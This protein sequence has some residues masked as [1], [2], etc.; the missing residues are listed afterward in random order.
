MSE[1]ETN[2][3]ECVA[4]VPSAAV[5]V[6]TYVYEKPPNTG[7]FFENVWAA[8][9]RNVVVPLPVGVTASFAETGTEDENWK[10]ASLEPLVVAYEA[11]LTLESDGAATG[12]FG[13]SGIE[14]LGDVGV[15]FG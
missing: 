13:V 12:G 10:C 4:I 11:T 7:I 6:I 15:W 8:S 2:E 3:P 5:A 1:Y 9:N 14:V